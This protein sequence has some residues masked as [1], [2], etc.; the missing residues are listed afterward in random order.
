MALTLPAW[1]P[2]TGDS[3]AHLLPALEGLARE[4]GY[5]VSYEKLPAA[6]GGYCDTE[7]KRIVIDAS[8][9]GNARVRTLIHEVAHGLGVTYDNYRR[10]EAEVI[11]ETVTYIVAAGAGLDTGSESIAYV[12]GWGEDGALEQVQAA[13][14]RVDAIARR[15]EAALEPDDPHEVAAASVEAA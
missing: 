11:V 10:D 7:A 5:A 9:A 8:N 15:I 1:A 12:A 6:L 2:L 4:L 14:Q 13:A 3:H